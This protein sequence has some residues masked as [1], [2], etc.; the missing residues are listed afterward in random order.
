MGSAIW[1]ILKSNF[2]W[3]ER[4]GPS[5]DINSQN[6]DFTHVEFLNHLSM[7]HIC[8]MHNLH[9]YPF[10]KHCEN[11]GATNRFFETTSLPISSLE[12]FFVFFLWDIIYP[13]SL[14]F[15]IFR[16]FLMSNQLWK[17]TCPVKKW[18]ISSHVYL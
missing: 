16:I 11:W 1:E 13:E 5:N 9:F 6:V 18:F 4:F 14:F 15:R 2:F 7:M 10:L 8:S 3:Q 12:G 17:K